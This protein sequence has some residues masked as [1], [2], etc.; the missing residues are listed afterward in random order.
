MHFHLMPSFLAIDQQLQ[1]IETDNRID[2]LSSHELRQAQADLEELF[3]LDETIEVTGKKS[4]F[5]P[6][7]MQLIEQATARL[8]TLDAERKEELQSLLDEIAQAHSDESADLEVLQSEL[9]DFLY[10]A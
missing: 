8:G 4:T 10:Y 9:E 6:E 2:R 1:S 3:D 7:L 5:S